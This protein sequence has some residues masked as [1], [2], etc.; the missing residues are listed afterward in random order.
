MGGISR[1]TAL[2]T[3]LLM[4]VSGFLLVTI[5]GSEGFV[6]AALVLM[7]FWRG[8]KCVLTYVWMC[9]HMVAGKRLLWIGVILLDL[10]MVAFTVVDAP[11]VTIGFYLVLTY[12][13]R[14]GVDV[15][16]AVM[17]RADD[18]L[19]WQK[20]FGGLFRLMVALVCV[21]GVRTPAFLVVVW[22]MGLIAEGAIRIYEG[23][24]PTAVLFIP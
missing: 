13:Y 12:L 6:A 2:V 19:W 5:D 3:G 22:C 7:L 15:A 14:G 10:A 1:T 21:L 8:L 4:I 24:R 23:L 18:P 17:G 9:R 20:L 16:R 11:E